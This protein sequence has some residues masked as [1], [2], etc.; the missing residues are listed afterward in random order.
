M[1]AAILPWKASRFFCISAFVAL[2]LEHLHSL[3][4]AYRDLKPE[5]VM[6]SRDGVACISDM[7]LAAFV[8]EK[9]G[10][11]LTSRCGTPGYWSPECCRKERYGLECDWWSFG[12][13]LY[14][15]VT[16]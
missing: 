16:G 2:G 3:G 7:G 5:N 15:L 10:G 4:I 1:H 9:K 12:C 11:K 6:L 14:E 8:D 13:L